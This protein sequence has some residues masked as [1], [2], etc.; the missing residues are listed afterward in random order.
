L[1]D[2]RLKLGPVRLCGSAD[3]EP[4]QLRVTRTATFEDLAFALQGGT[5]GLPDVYVVLDVRTANEYRSS[6]VPDAVHIPL[7]ELRTRLAEIPGGTVWV[8]CGSGYRATAAA[9]V[10]EQAGRQAVV[11]DDHFGAAAGAGVP[12]T[13]A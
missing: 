4:G 11:V 10:L 1:H 2:A 6:H 7:Y 9:S 13:D 8:H 12:T 5:S 3:L